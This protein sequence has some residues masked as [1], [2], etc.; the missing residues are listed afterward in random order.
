MDKIYIIIPVYNVEAFLERCL[1]SILNQ[2]YT[3]Y[4]LVLID[5]GSTDRSGIICNEY[6]ARY[7][8]IKVIHQEN[9]GISAARNAG[10]DYAVSKAGDNSWIA[11]IDSDDYIHPKYLEYLLY[12]AKN[13]NTSISC[14][15]YKS[16][17]QG[18]NF[19]KIDT[20]N[21]SLLTPETLWTK[22]RSNALFAWGKLYSSDLYSSIRYPQGKIYE[23]EATTYKLL[24]REEQ[25]A[26]ISEPLYFYWVNMNSI[27]QKEWT[28]ARL[29]ELTAIEE[30]IEYFK[31]NG[32]RLARGKSAE[33]LC[34]ICITNLRYVEALSPKYD[35]LKK[36]LKRRLKTYLL[37]YGKEFGYRKAIYVWFDSRIRR[38]LKRVLKNE[39]AIHFVRR[40]MNKLFR[41]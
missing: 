41:K 1:Q 5:D 22:D 7:D 19:E 25:I 16:L 40:R 12:A 10:I 20:F 27:T 6:A 11:F 17:K 21:F 38:P 3:D 26:Y 39:S 35:H 28:P 23:D 9:G 36:P 34:A 13:G 2:T 32:Y 8:K 18:E 33:T 30:Q 15:Y 29:D 4:E 37:N 24:F 31:E 14:C